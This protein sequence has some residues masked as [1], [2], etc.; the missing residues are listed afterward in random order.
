MIAHDTFMIDSNHNG[1]IYSHD[2][3][4]FYFFPFGGCERKKTLKMYKACENIRSCW[5]FDLYKSDP[6]WNIDLK[7]SRCTLHL[8]NGTKH[9][10]HNCVLWPWPVDL[11]PSFFW[12]PS[13]R[14]AQF[15]FLHTL[16]KCEVWA[17]LNQKRSPGDLCTSFSNLPPY[18]NS[19]LLENMT[20]KEYNVDIM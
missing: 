5:P 15:V 17:F 12:P 9:V 3:S 2:E 18:M 8:G 1:C 19:L 7:F 10:S 16:W 14:R 11:E 4:L 20:M 13:G 6:D